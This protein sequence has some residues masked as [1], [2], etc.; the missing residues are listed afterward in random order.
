VKFESE[1]SLK[2]P[3]AKTWYFLL[4]LVFI[5]N[6]DSG[7]LFKIFLLRQGKEIHDWN[8]GAKKGSSAFDPRNNSKNRRA[9][10][11]INF[12]KYPLNLV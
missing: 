3:E 2:I 7:H 10:L 5:V 4:S 8:F 9:F 12:G 1:N 6:F 11:R